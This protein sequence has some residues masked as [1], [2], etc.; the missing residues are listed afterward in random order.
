MGHGLGTSLR[1][2]THG[3]RPRRRERIAVFFWM[4]IANKM[5]IS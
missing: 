1:G 5:L 4:D 2:E 3:S